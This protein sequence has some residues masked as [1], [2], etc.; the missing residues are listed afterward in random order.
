MLKPEKYAETAEYS[1]WRS[2]RIQPS[3]SEHVYS[4]SSG[5]NFSYCIADA[6]NSCILPP[7]LHQTVLLTAVTQ[8]Q[9]IIV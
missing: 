7:L 9:T 1:G 4:T 2:I 6:V 3:T 5:A 8:S